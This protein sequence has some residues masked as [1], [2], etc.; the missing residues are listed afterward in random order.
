[1]GW[2]RSK[3]GDSAGNLVKFTGTNPPEHLRG[4]KGSW[5]N[6]CVFP[7]SES[8][9]IQEEPATITLI[10]LTNVH[11]GSRTEVS[12][13]VIIMAVSSLSCGLESS[14]WPGLSNYTLCGC[15]QKSLSNIW[16]SISVISDRPWNGLLQQFKPNALRSHWISPSNHQ[17]GW[18][19]YR[20]STMMVS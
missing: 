5:F 19:N 9:R 6:L 17:C 10:F 20:L 12:A 15:N 14:V 3:G 1:M 7:Y 18:S 11:P 13:D 2:N 8:S 16:S 4:L